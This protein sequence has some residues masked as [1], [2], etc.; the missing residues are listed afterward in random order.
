MLHGYEQ[1]MSAWSTL[2]RTMP[3]GD[4][5]PQ[6][7]LAKVML[8]AIR[9]PRLYHEVKGRTT[10]GRRPHWDAITTDEDRLW[11]RQAK[12]DPM[13]LMRLIRENAE[14]LDKDAQQLSQ[15]TINAYTEQPKTPSQK[16][17]PDSTYPIYNYTTG[18]YMPPANTMTPAAHPRTP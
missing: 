5:P 7:D 17:Q 1:Y 6:K 8:R 9:P 3:A 16:H 13:L 18:T 14:K 10:S 11:R 2:L 4:M 12:E 15:Q